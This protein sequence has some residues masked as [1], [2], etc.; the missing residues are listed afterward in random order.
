M[1]L[2]IIGFTLDVLGKILIG[3]A[4]YL[5]HCKKRVKKIENIISKERKLYAIWNNEAYD[6]GIKKVQ[7]KSIGLKAFIKILKLKRKNILAIGDNYNDKELLQSAGLTITADKSILDGDF[8][9]P[10]NNKDLPA[11]Q[12]MSRI[13]KLI[14]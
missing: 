14:S 1:V 5:V 4:V 11:E 8:Y 10:L 7:T 9:I 2:E 13:I 3:V 12:L 6:I